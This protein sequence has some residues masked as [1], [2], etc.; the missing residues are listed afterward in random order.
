[1]IWLLPPSVPEA[2][3]ATYRKTEKERQLAPGRG[4]GVAKGY[5][6]EEVWYSINHSILFEYGM[7]TVR[8]Y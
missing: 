6:G 4:G 5:D 1:M 8:F 3:P 7:R 2:R